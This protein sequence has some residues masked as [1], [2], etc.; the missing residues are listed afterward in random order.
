MKIFI[1]QPVMEYGTDQ[2]EKALEKNTGADLYL[3]PEGYLNDNLESACSL[4]QTYNKTIITG[5]KKPKDRAVIIYGS[6]GI[7]LDRAKY[8]DPKVIEMGRL[9]IGSLLCDELIL[10]GLST[11]SEKLDLIVHPIGVGMF[12]EGQFEEWM[13]LAKKNAREHQAIM[14]G[15]S[16]AN[17]S[18][19]NCGTSIPIA[20]GVNR[21][22]EEIFVMKNDTR[23]VVLD[24]DT[25]DN[26]ILA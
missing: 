11:V 3:Y 2:L 18:Y 13:N 14:L 19:K 20:Y 17:G 5:Y 15:T 9:K 10:Q 4:A 24:L 22:G 23:S 6:G 1:G 21:Y 25:L 12:S 16:H 8:D 7:V 26:E